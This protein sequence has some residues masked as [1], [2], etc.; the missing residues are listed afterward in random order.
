MACATVCATVCHCMAQ[1]CKS[2]KSL[3]CQCIC[4]TVCATVSLV[5]KSLIFNDY[6]KSVPLCHCPPYYVGGG[7]VGTHPRLRRVRAADFRSAII[8]PEVEQPS[9][10]LGRIGKRT[11]EAGHRERAARRPVRAAVGAASVKIGRQAG[12]RKFSPP[13][14]PRKIR[15][16]FFIDGRGFRFCAR[17]RRAAAPPLELG[18]EGAARRCRV[19]AL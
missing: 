18:A 9:G 1:V 14:G 17:S 19:V 8:I 15:K 16:I 12:Q 3:G 10:G 2:L 13:G 11:R 4:A 7:A 5:T 6:M